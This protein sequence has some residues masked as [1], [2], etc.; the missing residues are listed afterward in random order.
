MYGYLQLR[1]TRTQLFFDLFQNAF[2]FHPYLKIRYGQLRTLRFGLRT[3]TQTTNR[4][5]L[6]IFSK[7]RVRKCVCDL[8]ITET[9]SLILC[10]V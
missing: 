8:G 4:Y 2:A 7:R 3:I 6:A 5:V 9:V 1:F 10:T